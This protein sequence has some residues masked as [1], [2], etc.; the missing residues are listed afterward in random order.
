MNAF[1]LSTTQILRQP[2]TI[3]SIGLHSLTWSS[4]DHR[5]RNH[6]TSIPFRYNPIVQSIACGSSFIGKG[7]L[8]IGKVL[9]T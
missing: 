8:L 1:Q 9:A 5:G 2:S 4:G 3:E 6:Q 7:Y